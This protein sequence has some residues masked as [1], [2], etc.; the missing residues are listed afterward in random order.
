M[1]TLP[2]KY[3]IDLFIAEVNRVGSSSTQKIKI[4]NPT[5]SYPS[6]LAFSDKEKVGGEAAYPLSNIIRVQGSL[7]I[8]DHQAKKAS[9]KSEDISDI[10]VII[11]IFL[12]R[13]KI[14]IIF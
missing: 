1:P 5:N 4:K 10:N 12:K 3:P 14:S 2:S 8:Q 7:N 11:M 6:K 13:N 9:H